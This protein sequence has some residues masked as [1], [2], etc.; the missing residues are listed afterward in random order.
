M[1]V[2]HCVYAKTRPNR[3]TGTLM[4]AGPFESI[5]AEAFRKLGI[6]VGLG[7]LA[8]DYNSGVSTQI[9][10]VAAVTTGRH[11]TQLIQLGTK[12]G[13]YERVSKDSP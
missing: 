7:T 8:R 12:R 13:M 5:A 3:F 11:I 4:P 10:M 9:P 6:D 2:G 1:H